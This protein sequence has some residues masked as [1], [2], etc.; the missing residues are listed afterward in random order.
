MPS[1]P[2]APRSHVPLHVQGQVVGAG[3]GPLAEVAL[4][5]PVPRVLAVVAGQLI[6]TGELPAAA[7]PG[8][9]VGLLACGE[10]GCQW[11]QHSAC[12]H[13]PFPALLVYGGGPCPP[14]L[15]SFNREETDRAPL[16]DP[17]FLSP[18]SSHPSPNAS[19]PRLPQHEAHLCPTARTPPRA[20]AP[21]PV[22]AKKPHSPRAASQLCYRATPEHFHHG[23]PTS[24]H[25]QPSRGMCPS[26]HLCAAPHISGS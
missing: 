17:P 23:D 5:G 15:C 1:A 6:G 8:A 14:L 10:R 18:R 13:P 3:E 21:L 4:E 12:L 25:P 19:L 26:R 16:P 22:A 24:L 11:A 2:A 9:V 7:F 20:S